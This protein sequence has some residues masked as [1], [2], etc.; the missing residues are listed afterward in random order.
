MVAVSFDSMTDFSL[1]GSDLWRR[2]S[3][4]GSYTLNPPL[5]GCGFQIVIARFPSLPLPGVSGGLPF[6]V[7]C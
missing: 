7:L 1:I 6:A 2:D 4:V 3:G 5:T